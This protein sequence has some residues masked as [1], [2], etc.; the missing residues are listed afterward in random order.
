MNLELAEEVMKYRISHSVKETMEQFF[1]T[2]YEIANIVWV[3]GGRKAIRHRP[4]DPGKFNDILKR[5]LDG[6]SITQ[7]AKEFGVSKQ[8]ISYRMKYHG[9]KQKYVINHDK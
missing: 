1:L 3:F 2:R 5:L 6:K 8:N 9:Y 7:T 4:R